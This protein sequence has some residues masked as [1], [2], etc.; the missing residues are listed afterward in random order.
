[1]SK[2]ILFTLFSIILLSFISSSSSEIPFAAIQNPTH[3]LNPNNLN[4]NNL[5][6]NKM[7]IFSQ[8]NIQD[9]ESKKIMVISDV[10]IMSEKLLI[11]DGEAFQNYLQKDRKLLQESIAIAKELANKILEEK[12]ELVLVCGDLTKDGEKVSH[13]AF[14]EIFRPVVENGI[15]MLVIPGN[16]DVNN[17]N[18]VYFNGKN[19]EPA[20]TVSAKQFSEIYSDFGY[21]NAV[22]RDRNSLSYVSEP[23]EGLRVIAIDGCKYEE[24][25]FLS[26]GDEKNHCVTEG[27]IKPETMKWIKR[28]AKMA[29]NSGKQI[30]AMVHHNVVEHFDFQGEISAPYLL[31]NFREVQNHFMEAGIQV[32]F[33]GHFH[34]NDIAKTRD[35]KGNYLYDVETGS[36]VTYPC[37]Y[38]VIEYSNRNQLLI[39]TKF[40]EK[41]DYDLKG[42][43]FQ[44]YAKRII[45]ENIPAVLSSLITEFYPE[46]S[47]AAGS[48]SSFIKIPE[49][50]QLSRI[51]EDNF[52]E[53][54]VEL[55]MKIYEGSQQITFDYITLKKL[56]KSIENLAGELAR[57]KFLKG[58]IVKSFNNLDYVKKV[59]VAA[60]SIYFNMKG[61][62]QKVVLSGN[63]E[64]WMSKNREFI[65]DLNYP[66]FLQN[67]ILLSEN[68][69]EEEV[70]SP[71]KT[72]FSNP[73][74]VSTKNFWNNDSKW[75]ES[76]S[77]VKTE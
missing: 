43:D 20:E 11:K 76:S 46:I 5:N 56:N 14:V 57:K 66:I 26:K 74:F 54:A 29:L 75:P 53:I 70:K 61:L 32:V 12:P 72:I 51:V 41:I 49:S 71:E 19:E 39:S 52:G 37:P 18:A 73:L 23:T 22:S 2:K 17:P 35:N 58:R 63:I 30:I 42:E 69:I 9:K 10:H 45:K 21:S 6:D 38:R 24:N 36:P 47:Q 27:R 59:K 68:L 77:L 15:R 48:Y 34:A 40:I 7:K 64:K 4:T 31:E 25:L 62:D 55:M 50:H 33:T 60:H 28:E 1:M 67:P 16:H 44:A 8:S 13:Q 3:S 65:D